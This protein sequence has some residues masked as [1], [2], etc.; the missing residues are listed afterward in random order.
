MQLKSQNISKGPHNVQIIDNVELS[1]ET[2]KLVFK[3]EIIAKNSKPGQ[4]VSIL[5]E[6]LV[7]RRPFSVANTENDIFEIIYKLKGKGTKFLVS[8]RNND[9]ADVIGP[10][11]NGFNIENKNSLLIGCGVGIAPINFLS[12]KLESLNIKYTF[13]ECSQTFIGIEEK[14]KN[15]RIFITEDGSKGIKGR[16]DNHLENIIKSV[17]PKKIYTCGPN[18]A[19]AYIS[20]VAEKYKIP[21]EAAME[22]EFACG[23]GVCMGCVIQ[24]KENASVVNKRI[25]KD[26]PVFKGSEVLW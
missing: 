4:F 26:G 22:R 16:L 10:F 21:V 6:G 15:N 3:S 1:S 19:M 24:I 2:W 14:N 13:V 18:P 11:G 23:T 7:L 5:C 17:E 8:L 20:S 25:C 12:N 9:I